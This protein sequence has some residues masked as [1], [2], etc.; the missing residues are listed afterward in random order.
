MKILTT[1]SQPQDSYNK[2]KRLKI[3]KLRNVNMALGLGVSPLRR[4]HYQWY[5]WPKGSEPKIQELDAEF[6][7]GDMTSPC[8][9]L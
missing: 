6:W 3:S 1:G 9:C 7:G 5:M 4:R 2:E 8:C